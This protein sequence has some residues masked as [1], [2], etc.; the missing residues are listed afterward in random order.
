MS[1]VVVARDW[2]DKLPPADPKESLLISDLDID[3]RTE[4]S[5]LGSQ[6]KMTKELDG[7]T[8]YIPDPLP[9]DIC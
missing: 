7:I 3:V 2:F 8:V 5:R 9:K 6:I 4:F 1:S